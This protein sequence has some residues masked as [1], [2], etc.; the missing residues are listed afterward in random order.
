MKT[1]ILLLLGFL[2]FAC[3]S[4]NSA[5]VIDTFKTASGKTIKIECYRHASLNIIYNGH[6]IQIDP[7]NDPEHHISYKGK[8]QADCI[9][10]THEHSDHFDTK[11]I[12]E[13]SGSNT[14]VI[15]NKNTRDKLGKGTAMKNGDELTLNCGV[16][17][18]AIPAY[19]TTAGHQKFHPQ[20]RDNGYLL[21]IENFRIYISG[22]TE[23]IP[24]M[25][26]LG[27]IDI[28]FLPC[29]QPYT[30]TVGQLVESAKIIRP[31]ILF[32]YHYSDTDMSKVAGL[33]K[34][35]SIEVRLRNME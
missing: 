26:N 18:K 35:S 24:E 23:V 5:Q 21:T 25:H 27:K 22:D 15:L 29:N 10:I 8:P 2:F 3:Q 19:N 9:L 6:S 17:I 4:I 20:G 1:N 11:A 16:K 28:A 32:P 31:H 7:V 33:L 34:S 14:Q 12:A 13:L 30:M